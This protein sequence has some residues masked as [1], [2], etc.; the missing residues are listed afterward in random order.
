MVRVAAGAVA[1]AVAITALAGCFATGGSGVRRSTGTI[2]VGSSA[3]GGV[4]RPEPA[5][6]SH[7]IVTGS[8]VNLRAGPTTAYEVLAQASRS[9]R[10]GVVSS[11][12]G[13]FEVLLPPGS[14][15]WLAADYVSVSDA[16]RERL[17]RSAGAG[18]VPVEGRV[19]GDDVRVR[20]RAG[21][22]S[23]VLYK[24]YAGDRV[25]VNGAKAVG[26][27]E[28][29]PMTWYRILLDETVTGWI[30]AEFAELDAGPDR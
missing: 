4:S 10:L 21:L 12:Y 26:S 20:A 23:T 24:A 13:W 25:Q 30:S 29:Q 9:A 15:G 28:G 17:S 3:R 19:T 7:I 6:T 27:D 22:R 5:V 2:P 14:T 8:R 16:A 18:V 11:R 1:A